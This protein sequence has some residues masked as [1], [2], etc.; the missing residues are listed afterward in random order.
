MK[1][2]SDCSLEVAPQ[3]QFIISSNSEF[4]IISELSEF[5]SN[6]TFFERDQNILLLITETYNTI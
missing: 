4:F 6:L 3:S 2:Q 1:Q 5:V